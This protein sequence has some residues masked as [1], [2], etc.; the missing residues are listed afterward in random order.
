MT[1]S[2]SLWI[3]QLREG[4]REAT[5]KLWG[6]YFQRM[7]EVARRKLENR[8]RLGADAEDV[9][10]SAFDSFF[11]GAEQGRFPQLNDRDDLWHVLVTI[12]ARKAQRLLRDQSRL[13]RGAGAVVGESALLFA[14]SNDGSGPS[15]DRMFSEDPDPVF[16]AQLTED[17]E[18]LFSQLEDEDLKAVVVMKMEGY[19]IDEM[20]A[21]LGRAPATIE[22]KLKVVRVLWQADLE[23]QEQSQGTA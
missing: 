9:A 17:F 19:T 15:L 3:D 5:S 23:A 16:V 13:K 7:I 10:L 12:T 14:D 21:K 22:R 20:S 8:P 1:S 4:E 6:R 11:R 2:V 18:R